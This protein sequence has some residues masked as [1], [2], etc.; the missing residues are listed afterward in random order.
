LGF[1]IAIR[2][3]VLVGFA[4]RWFARRQ[5]D[6]TSALRRKSA[7]GNWQPTVANPNF[8]RI[9]FPS[10]IKQNGFRESA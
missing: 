5:A 3:G 4:H 6:E 10:I 2:A 1:R 9:A 7:H 8:L